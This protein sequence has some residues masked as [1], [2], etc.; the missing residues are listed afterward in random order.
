MIL[1]EPLQ[2]P[3]GGG[4]F[5]TLYLPGQANTISM[6]QE[7]NA[8]HELDEATDRSGCRHGDASE[9]TRM[10]GQAWAAHPGARPYLVPYMASSLIAI[11]PPVWPPPFGRSAMIRT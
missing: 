2:L 10:R 6:T 7:G 9:R 5:S 11:C 1:P 3:H 4:S 8:V